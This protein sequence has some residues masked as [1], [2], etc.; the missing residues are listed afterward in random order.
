MTTTL[1][2][3]PREYG[4]GDIVEPGDY[5]DLETGA[6]V[7]VHERDELPAGRIV[8]YHRRFRRVDASQYVQGKDSR[9]SAA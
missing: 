7:H 5:I 1:E 2:A 4:S 8:I 6:M 9:Q 3:Q